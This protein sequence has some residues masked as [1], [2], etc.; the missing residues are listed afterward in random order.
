M[1]LVTLVNNLM[2]HR[3]SRYNLMISRAYT[4]TLQVCVKPLVLEKKN[5]K[6]KL[7]AKYF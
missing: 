7:I 6:H 1:F 4:H 3:A 5:D 2:Y